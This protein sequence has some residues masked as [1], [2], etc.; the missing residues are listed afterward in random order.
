MQKTNVIIVR[1]FKEKK[2]AYGLC[3]SG[4]QVFVHDENCLDDLETYHLG[5]TI[6]AF[7]C[8][9][10]KGKLATVCEKVKESKI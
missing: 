5:D 4:E 9:S 2:Y 7:L 10:P 1:V 8:N 6:T 3:E